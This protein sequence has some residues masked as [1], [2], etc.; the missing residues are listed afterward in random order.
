MWAGVSLQCPLVISVEIT[1]RWTHRSTA[2]GLGRRSGLEAWQRISRVEVIAEGKMKSAQ[3]Q[4]ECER[5]SQA[6][7]SQLTS[8]KGEHVQ[9]QS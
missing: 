6:R 5:A 7:A 3:E 2:A 1:A 8:E 9:P 4:R